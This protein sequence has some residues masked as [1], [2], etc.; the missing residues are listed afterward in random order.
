MQTYREL[1]RAP[2][3]TP[4]FLSSAV[5]VAATTIA[6]LALGVLVF[7]TTG[8]PLLAALSM[9][10]PSLVQ[11]LGA[12]TL[13]SAADRL[14]PRA[15][16]T[17]LALGVGL[18][19]AAQALPGLPSWAVF[20]LLL[21]QGFVASIG[22]GVRYGLLR[23]LLPDAG[24]LLGRSTLAM[25]T[26]L[27]QILGF[28]V[29]GVLVSVLYARG[30]LLVAA[31]LFV[32]AGLIARCWLDERPPRTTGRPSIAATR[33][34]NAQLWSSR[35]RRTTL[36]GTW[37]PNGLVAGCESLFVPYAPERAGLLLAAAAL[38][39]LIGDTVV[40]RFVPPRWRGALPAPLL[41][42]LAAPY[43]LFALEPSMPV[44]AAAAGMASVGF[45]STLLLLDRLMVQTPAELSG[46]ALGLQNAGM[47]TMQG[48]GAAI[49]GSVA[50][51]T[52][53]ATAIAAMAGASLVA[54]AVLARHWH[55]ERV[56]V[57]G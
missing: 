16:L 24:Y 25:S 46:Q 30:T 8:S 39:M 38:G 19:T 10:G 22:G 14:P 49:A 51:L 6:G 26:G 13:L 27:V 33:A 5:Q 12:T 9:F 45:G 28:A 2:G 47:L 20:V 57:P 55:G 52:T 35:P 1:V 3:F 48:V 21:A 34:A 40:G 42:L 17:A 54:T 44:A 23:E 56:S 37:V 32:V 41:V 36:L 11:V 15:T 43:L 4:L 18:T 29:G 50:Q 7:A 31:G 53:P